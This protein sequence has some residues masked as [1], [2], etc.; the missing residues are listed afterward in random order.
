ME[1]IAFGVDRK[2]IDH[3]LVYSCAIQAQISDLIETW[4][5]RYET[6]VGE[7]GVKL[8]GGQRQRIGIARALYKKAQVIIFDEA[9]SALD[10]LTESEVMNAMSNLSEDL[11]I[12]IVAH[13]ISTLSFCTRIYNIKEGSI[14]Q[15]SSEDL[16]NLKS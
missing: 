9:T 2:K 5:N 11:T 15:V 12:V 4:P 8:S 1:N 14:D 3:D 7:R 16:N 6:L 13:R 10:S